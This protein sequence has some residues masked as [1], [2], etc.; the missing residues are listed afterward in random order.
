MRLRAIR[1]P[2]GDHVV[3]RIELPEKKWKTYNTVP[4]PLDFVDFALSRV[5]VEWDDKNIYYDR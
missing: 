2:T 3:F 4:M 5:I 1:M